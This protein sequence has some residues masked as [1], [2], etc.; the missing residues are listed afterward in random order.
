MN[1]QLAARVLGTLLVASA[2]GCS[3]SHTHEDVSGS[4][5][6]IIDACH[7]LD[8]GSGPIHDCHEMSESSTEETCNS[9][10]ADCLSVCKPGTDA[11]GAS[12]AAGTDA[13]HG[14]HDGGAEAAASDGSA[15]DA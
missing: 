9:K 10:K 13:T 6:A 1:L 12:D 7:P 3:D 11:G 4:C 14:D 15:G 5:K 8:T 2:L